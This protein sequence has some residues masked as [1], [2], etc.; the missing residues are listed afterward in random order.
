MRKIKPVVIAMAIIMLMQMLTS[1]SSDKKSADVIKEDDPWYDTVKFKLDKEY[2]K[3]D[4][5]GGEEVFTSNDRIFSLYCASS[6]VWATSKTYL[7]AY[8]YEGNLIKR[9]KVTVE[10]GCRIQSVYSAAADPEGKNIKAVV[11]LN[12]E[13]MHGFS[14]VNIDAETGI[15]SDIKEVFSKE[16]KTAVGKTGSISDVT[17]I[18]DYSVVLLLGDYSGGMNFPW[19]IMLYKDT[20]FVVKF[21]MSTLNINT[22]L[23]G[24]SI[25]E[26]SASLYAAGI[27]NKEVIIMEFDIKNGK[28]KSKENIQEISGETVNYAEYTATNDGDLC[29]IDSF[30]NIMKI[31]VNDMTPQTVIDT[32]WYTPYFSPASY[33]AIFEQYGPNIG[34]GSY[35][36]SCTEERT[37]IRDIE[38]RSYG[39]DDFYSVDY[40]RVLKKADKNPHAGKQII[41]LAM[42]L[43]TG[44]S[45]YLGEAISEFN[46]TDNEYL[47]RVWDKYKT[48][49]TLGR[50]VQSADENETKTYEM[51]QDLK[52]DGAPDIAIG[53]QKNYAMRDDVFMDLTGFLDP[54][55]EEQQYGNI[56]EAGRLDGKLYFLPVTLQIEGLVT[57]A[58]L[59]KDGAAGITFE[60]YE[61]M[62]KDDLDGFSPYDYPYS[63][64]YNKRSFVLSCIDTK[65]A[66]EGDEI[67]F[68]TDQFRSAIEY[69]KDNFNY[70]DEKST[71]DEYLYD[72]DHRERSECYYAKIRD[73]LEYVHACYS[74]KDRYV[75][76]GTPSVDAKGPRFSALETI[77]VSATTDVKD[78]CRRFVNFLFSG[79]A[80]SSGDCELRQIVTNRE[81]MKRNVE[82][83]SKLNNEAYE[84]YVQAKNNKAIIPNPKYER[85]QGD[86]TSTDEMRES[87]LNSMSTISTYYYEDY[88]IVK[89]VTEEVAP[90]YAGDRSVDDVVRFLNDRTT[91][92]IRE[93]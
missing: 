34:F 67:D 45:S 22:F 79:A 29:K 17:N 50:M 18:G 47:I 14:F 35:I 26:S 65:S 3:T 60:D 10:N 86:K 70:D 19:E 42:P 61:K 62:V 83:L 89:F 16:V 43:D 13:K 90:F 63:K 25:D 6:D 92:Y 93:M 85:A 71:P 12:S 7:D 28:L 54:E 1:C 76:I 4:Q 30:G 2:K 41:E 57:N 74:S 77:S 15:I 44:I 66:I 21:D 64:Y 5:I 38:T 27:E 37:V 75:I 8:D 51:I 20:E 53:I 88:Q 78:G 84:R 91:K 73:Y 49:F 24:F 52:D 72:I 80:F 36:V 82:T 56:I 40:I 69:A 46:K 31:D 39:S 33:S 59:L 11:Y 58:E 23:D 55:V 81:I 87:F 32:N 68:G 9:Q 48:G